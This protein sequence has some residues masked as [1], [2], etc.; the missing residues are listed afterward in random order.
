MV[1][2]AVATSGLLLRPSDLLT[3][4]RPCIT[5]KVVLAGMDVAVLQRPACVPAHTQRSGWSRPSVEAG[6]DS[7][8]NR[9]K[10]PA[11]PDKDPGPGLSPSAGQ[12][13]SFEEPPQPCIWSFVQGPGPRARLTLSVC[14]LGIIKP[15]T[16]LKTSR[17][18]GGSCCLPPRLPPNLRPSP[19]LLVVVLE[20]LFIGWR[21]VVTVGRRWRVEGHHLVGG[22]RLCPVQ[23][24][25]AW[26]RGLS[27]CYTV[28]PLQTSRLL[29][30]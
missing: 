29:R 8:L 17:R 5:A 10:P 2:A 3:L 11:G 7:A 12:S 16:P 24:V 25:C 13:I 6:Q 14:S 9:N 26:R 18:A 4:Q 21:W 22:A 27:T 30:S 28:D 20:H 19:S 23:W 15:R 1:V